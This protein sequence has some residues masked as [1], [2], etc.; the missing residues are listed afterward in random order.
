[1]PK[2]YVTILNV[3]TYTSYILTLGSGN[4]IPTT[5]AAEL[6]NKLR[7]ILGSFTVTLDINNGVVVSASTSNP[8]YAFK[9]LTDDDLVSGKYWYG[10][11][12]NKND[13]TSA[14]DLINNRV[15]SN[16]FIGASATWKSG[17]LNLNSINNIYQ[18]I[19]QLLHYLL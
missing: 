19:F 18:K 9:I 8:A 2:L 6:Q 11:S 15:S 7:T 4:Y 14:N 12:Y 17:F 3:T 10:A 13:L 16:G 5:F 1:L